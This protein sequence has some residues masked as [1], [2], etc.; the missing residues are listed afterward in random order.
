MV[1]KYR[2]DKEQKNDRKKRMLEKMATGPVVIPDDQEERIG[3]VNVFSQE[4]TAT[5]SLF[6]INGASSFLAMNNMKG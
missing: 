4:V 5:S 3:R 2:Q 6:F 1:G